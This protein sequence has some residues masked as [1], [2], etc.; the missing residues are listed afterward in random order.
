MAIDALVIRQ[1]AQ[2]VISGEKY[3]G[4]RSGKCQGE[5]IGKRQRR[6]LVAISDSAGNTVAI[7]FFN[8][9]AE[10]NELVASVILEFALIQKIR[11]GKL[12]RKAEAGLKK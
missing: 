3:P 12:V 11:N 1:L 7:Q 4:I 10:F 5:T 9:Q 8:S 2:S 6:V